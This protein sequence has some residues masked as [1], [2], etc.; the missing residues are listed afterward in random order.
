MR[1][2][3]ASRYV[4][5]CSRREITAISLSFSLG[6]KIR[7]RKEDRERHAA[8]LNLLLLCSLALGT[9]VINISLI[10]V[11]MT[12]MDDTAITFALRKI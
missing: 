4:F 9:R 6:N 12:L 8:C 5:T 7:D 11:S 1:A 2:R 3:R 10:L